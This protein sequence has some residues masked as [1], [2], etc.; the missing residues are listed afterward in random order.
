MKINNALWEIVGVC[1]DTVLTDLRD[2]PRPTV[3]FSFRQSSSGSAY[4]AVRTALPPL[5]LVAAA[6]QAVAA[7]DPNVPVAHLTTQEALRDENIAQE[8]M[9]AA[10]C[11]SL[12]GLA[13]LLSGIGLFGLMG[14]QVAR[15]TGEIGVRI[16]LG[17]TG[18][19]IARPI[20]R[21]ALLLAGI[22]LA[23][24]LP[25]AVALARFIKHQLYGVQ[26]TD[27]LTLIAG[28]GVLVAVALAA[29]SVPAWRAARVDPM[30]A[31][32]AE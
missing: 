15:R 20:L 28:S 31:L 1:G 7:I 14:Y 25:T 24:G 16:A 4:F 18:R 2:E 3:Y 26:P 13:V 19:D 27:P 6:R 10:L 32:R 5:A 17:A 11:G 29:A 21:E 8:R 9:F 12:A 22:G 23:V 30:T